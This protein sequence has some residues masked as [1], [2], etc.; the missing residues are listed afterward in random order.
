ME[1]NI[2]MFEHIFIM[3][4]CHAYVKSDREIEAGAGNVATD[5]NAVVAN[6][7]YGHSGASNNIRIS[8]GDVCWTRRRFY[9]EFF[10]TTSQYFTKF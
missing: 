3:I 9:L 5:L 6:P 4:S 8:V 7:I 1:Q 10:K 2:S